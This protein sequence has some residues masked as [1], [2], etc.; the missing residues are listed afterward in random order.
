MKKKTRIAKIIIGTFL[1]VIIATGLGF[2]GISRWVGVNFSDP[3]LFVSEHPDTGNKA[4]FIL[5]GFV[6]RGW[7]LY[8]KS[9][10]Q[11]KPTPV[12]ELDWDGRCIFIGAEWSKDGQVITATLR[13]IGGTYPEICAYAY[14]FKSNRA[15][16]PEGTSRNAMLQSVNW[17]SAQSNILNIVEAHGGF[18]GNFISR[19]NM[20][21]SGKSIW[22]WQIP[23]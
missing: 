5:E 15:L 12:T 20:M 21:Q 9:I 13:I 11:K 19:D 3:F 6:D 7:S 22:T 4:L 10:T 18:C 14:D 16:M 17:L 1:V 23:K 8:A 2:I